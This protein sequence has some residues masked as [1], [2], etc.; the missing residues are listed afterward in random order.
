VVF[1]GQFV[2]DPDGP[3]N[4]GT[5]RLFSDAN[6]RAYYSGPS[7]PFSVGIIS[8]VGAT[9]LGDTAV[10]LVTTPSPQS[11][12]A[13]IYITFRRAGSDTFNSTKMTFNPDTGAWELTL[14]TSAG[15]GGKVAEYF[16]QMV[17]RDGDVS[18][19]TF[20]ALFSKPVPPPPAPGAVTITVTDSDG[21][22]ISPS[23]AGWYNKSS[24]KVDITRN[25]ESFTAS[26]DGGSQQ[27]VPV[28]VTGEG[29]HVV[30]FQGDQG[31]SGHFEVPI[32][33]VKPDITIT[34]P[35]NGATYTLNQTVAADYSCTDATSGVASCTGT[36]PSGQNIDTGSIGAKTFTVN[37]ADKADNARSTQVTY[38]V[39]YGV[40][41]LYDPGTPFRLSNSTIPLKLSIC[42]AN[43]VN[44]SSASITL[45][46]VD[47][48]QYVPSLPDCSGSPNDEKCWK[49]IAPP[50][51][52]P[53][54]GD[55][56]VFRFDRK[57]AP[58]GGYIYNYS[59][60]GLKTNSTYRLRFTASNEAAGTAKHSAQFSTK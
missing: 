23:A 25:D 45:T 42:D 11:D 19:S 27:P 55:G 16:A 20:K 32:D 1:G 9:D 44:K 24:V 39:G 49:T 50:N 3:P 15:A 40:C 4:T 57:L 59:T 28:A 53:N 31:S 35:I 37:A 48:Q 51:L 30:A 43:K 2:S 60:K 22:P 33:S 58:G 21:N 54:A 38:Y 47:L 36:K 18:A 13:A 6:I 41:L 46:A 26:V 8:S 29:V 7:N 56:F 14:D 34:S 10:F 52:S 5:Q 17:T 12:V